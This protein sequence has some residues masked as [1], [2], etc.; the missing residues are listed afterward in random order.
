[1]KHKHCELIK[2]WADGAVIQIKE[3]DQWRDVQDN[4]PY[5]INDSE[6][7]VKPEK[8]V[9]KYR[10]YRSIRQGSQQ[11]DIVCG[12][13]DGRRKI[14]ELYNDFGEWLTDELEMEVTDE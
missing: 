6:Y 5:W 14:V 13:T 11:P 1:M 12:Y 10:I 3:F 2:Q 9:I 8:K 4:S 7:R